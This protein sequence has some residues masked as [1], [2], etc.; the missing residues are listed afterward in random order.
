M[1]IESMLTERMTRMQEEM[2][3]NFMTELRSRDEEIAELRTTIK[4]LEWTIQYKSAEL[5]DRDFRLSL[6]KNCNYDGTMV[7]KIPQFSQQ[8]ADAEN[9]KCT[10]IYTKTMPTST[11]R[12]YES[13]Y[14]R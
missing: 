9:G 5:K 7:R 13:S 12:L 3:R 2:R 10:G 6:I 11:P 4:K 1:I 8:K 14:G